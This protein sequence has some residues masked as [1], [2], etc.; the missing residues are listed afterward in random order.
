MVLDEVKMK[1]RERNCLYHEFLKNKTDGNRQQYLES[2]RVANKAAHYGDVGKKLDTRDGE[3]II[4]RLARS[5][6]RQS[7]DVEKFYGVNDKPVIS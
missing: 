7:E 3:R 4:Y 1:V 6:Q 2:K 5:R